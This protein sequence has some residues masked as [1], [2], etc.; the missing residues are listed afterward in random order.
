MGAPG[1]GCVGRP[2]ALVLRRSAFDES[3]P[4]NRPVRSYHPRAP[5]SPG[6]PDVRDAMPILVPLLAR[7][8]LGCWIVAGLA[9]A[10]ETPEPTPP[11]PAASG[12]PTE[13]P[14]PQ[15]ETPPSY[16]FLEDR[17]ALLADWEARVAAAGSGVLLQRLEL[18]TSAGGRELFGL[19]FGA[20]G[21]RPLE[22]R[23]TVL[24][25]GGL[26]GTS[27]SGSQAVLRIVSAL[28]ARPTGLPTEAT[29][30]AVPWANPD[31]LARWRSVACGGGRNDRRVDEDGDGV[32]DEDG[33]DDLDGDGL[34]L[35]MLIEQ[36]SGS[37][38]RSADN[39]FLRPALEGE[40]PRYERLREGR[41]DDG[42]GRFNEDGPGGV[43]LDHNFPVG[44]ED[45]GTS[46]AGPWPLSEPESEALARLILARRTAVVVVMQGNHGL[47]AS[48]GGREL[49]PGRMILPLPEDEPTYRRLV[50]VFAGH[51][52]RGQTSAVHLR[53]ARGGAWPGSLID[54]AYAARGSLAMEI[55]VWGPHV[56]GN[57]RGPVAAYYRAGT[58]EDGPRAGVP[59]AERA[60]AQWLDE[61]RGGFGFVDWQP[62]ELA[63]TSGALVG[64][65]LPQTCFDPP[66]D[67]LPQTCKGLDGFVLDLAGNLPRLEVELRDAKREG[68]VCWLKARVKNL[69][70]LPSGVGPRSPETSVKLRLE[71]APG[72]NL[73]AGEQET[74]LGHLPGRGVSEESTWILSAPEGSVFRVIVESPW[75][76]PAVREVRL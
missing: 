66:V 19:Q 71:I 20:A 68:R 22:D 56:E 51:A 39:R 64:G 18:G 21:G 1:W 62:V 9:R 14:A 26:D 36:P 46:A 67:A 23:A 44:W 74:S 69:G 57:G 13:A 58:E 73:V 16:S 43:Q 15:A 37:W 35:E 54:W 48:P 2:K 45:D 3:G 30:L 11:S 63:G 28:L 61:T 50:E 4:R 47:L 76:P 49:A 17:D 75:S 65:W 55:A 72:V 41:D 32:I 29:F 6:R 31:G 38:V 42:D 8:L 10:Q 52:G 27:L 60:W 12:A 53:D 5:A 40:A 7:A 34:I 70:T 25:L 24:L 59:P 33:P